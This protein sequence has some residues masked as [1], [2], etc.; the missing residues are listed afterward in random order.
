MLFNKRKAPVCSKE[1]LYHNV[2]E[3]EIIIIK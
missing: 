1:N 2:I 3:L